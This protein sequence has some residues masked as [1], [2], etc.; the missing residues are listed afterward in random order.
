MVDAFDAANARSIWRKFPQNLHFDEAWRKED[1]CAECCSMYKGE[2]IGD[3]TA[4]VGLVSNS[5]QL[6]A[7]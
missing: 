1:R 3:A 7:E 4:K 6:E 5:A 2:N